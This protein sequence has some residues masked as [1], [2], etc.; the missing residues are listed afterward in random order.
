MLNRGLSAAFKADW[1]QT[2]TSTLHDGLPGGI[3]LCSPQVADPGVQEL[4]DNKKDKLRVEVLFIAFR[5]YR[6]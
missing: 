3:V 2:A 1:R 6:Q 5:G 4:N